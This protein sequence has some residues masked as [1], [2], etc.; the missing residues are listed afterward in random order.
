MMKLKESPDSL[1]LDIRT[2]SEADRTYI[3]IT[4][5][6]KR[7]SHVLVFKWEKGIFSPKETDLSE[8]GEPVCVIDGYDLI[9]HKGGRASIGGIAGEYY[10][11]AARR[12]GD[13]VFYCDKSS[14]VKFEAGEHTNILYSATR[15]REVY[16]E[17][18]K[19]TVSFKP[20]V[21]DRTVSFIPFNDIFYII[22]FDNT[23]KYPISE[24]MLK[25]DKFD[26]FV[27][28]DAHFSLT[29]VERS[30]IKISEI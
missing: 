30:H 14:A 21:R 20:S 24:K 6:A 17:C 28:R 1:N 19:I 5:L 2:E 22:G 3:I 8:W 16:P 4:G 7:A 26:V 29:C 27:P 25:D 13:D 18:D 23:L 9:Y 12:S 10:A 15:I 11:A